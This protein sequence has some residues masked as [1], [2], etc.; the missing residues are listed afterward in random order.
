MVALIQYT[1][2]VQLDIRRESAEGRCQDLKLSH[3]GPG[4]VVSPRQQGFP[5]HTSQ[6]DLGSIFQHHA[7]ENIRRSYGLIFVVESVLGIFEIEL[8]IWAIF[9]P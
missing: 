1:L 6:Y 4:D 8:K 7:A 3:V 9:L 2:L 5:Q